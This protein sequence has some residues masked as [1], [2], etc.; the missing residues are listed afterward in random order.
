M[1]L[2]LAVLFKPIDVTRMDTILGT[3]N[4]VIATADVIS[5]VSMNEEQNVLEVGTV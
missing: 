2:S 3:L 4:D 1:L 5:Q